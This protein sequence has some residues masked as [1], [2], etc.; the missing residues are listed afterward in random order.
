[1]GRNPTGSLGLAAIARAAFACRGEE[2]SGRPLV[3]KGDDQTAE[4]ADRLRSHLPQKPKIKTGTV[5]QRHFEPHL[6]GSVSTPANAGW[7]IPLTTTEPR[8]FKQNWKISGH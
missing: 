4:S 5:W 3:I 1:M 2:N 8:P 6:T 7:L